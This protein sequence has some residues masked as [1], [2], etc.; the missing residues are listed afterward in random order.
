MLAQ[1]LY[2]INSLSILEITPL[3]SSNMNEADKQTLI[4]IL[5]EIRKELERAKQFN[6]KTDMLVYIDFAL[7]DVRKGL[8]FLNKSKK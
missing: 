5:S 7:S 6:D 1:I 2:I 3:T 8:D 4:I